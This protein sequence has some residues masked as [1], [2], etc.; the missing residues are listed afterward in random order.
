MVSRGV[1]VGILLAVVLLVAASSY[2]YLSSPKANAPNACNNATSSQLTSSTQTYV[3]LAN[4]KVAQSAFVGGG[5]GTGTTLSASCASIPAQSYVMLTNIGNGSTSVTGVALYF[6]A[7]TARAAPTGC[8]IGGS[9][10]PDDTLYLN[11]NTGGS[12]L[13][14]G[15]AG[16][17]VVVTITLANG[18]QISGTSQFENMTS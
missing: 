15:A 12:N 7:N 10:S 5:S 13:A 8:E 4:V 17:P 3:C 6:G 16:D 2:A 14:F 1:W 9:G 18:E 11:F